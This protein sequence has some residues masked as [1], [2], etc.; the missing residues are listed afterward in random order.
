M[1]APASSSDRAQPPSEA[2]AASA[3]GETLASARPLPRMPCATT[4]R[5]TYR[6][7]IPSMASAIA[8]GTVREVS[9]TSPLGTS[10]HSMP[11]N[12]KIRSSDVRATSA[13]AGIASTRRFAASMKNMPPMATSNSGR[14]FATVAIEFSRTPSVTPRRFTIDQKP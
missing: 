4:C 6:S 9:R 2:P 14:S 8:R 12:A 11:A 7:V 13:A 3:S 10:A 5:A 1:L